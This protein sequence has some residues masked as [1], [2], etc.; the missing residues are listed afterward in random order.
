MKVT[1]SVVGP[2]V[3]SSS[4]SISASGIGINRNKNKKIG[5]NYI[6]IKLIEIHKLLF[7]FVHLSI[8][9]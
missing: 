8:F 4:P 9:N 1:T 6:E 3:I 2:S 5:I 7:N